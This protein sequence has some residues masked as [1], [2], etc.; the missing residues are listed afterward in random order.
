MTTG[1]SKSNNTTTL[2][3]REDE[4]MASPMLAPNQSEKLG[5]AWHILIP[6]SVERVL[7]RM[8]VTVLCVP[9]RCTVA[10]CTRVAE[11]FRIV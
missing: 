2:T 3:N 6:S 1:R 8:C 5:G 9:C 11:L 4:D 10:V 7:G